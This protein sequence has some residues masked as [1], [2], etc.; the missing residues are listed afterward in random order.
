MSVITVNLRKA[1]HKLGDLLDQVVQGNIVRLEN[2]AKG[3]VM[4]LLVPPEYLAQ[5]V[6]LQEAE[7]ENGDGKCDCGATEL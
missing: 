7:R 5:L 2:A 6:A 3:K 1:H 4:A